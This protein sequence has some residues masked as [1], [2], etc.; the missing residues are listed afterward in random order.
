MNEPMTPVYFDTYKVLAAMEGQGATRRGYFIE[1]L[2]GAQFAMP[3]AVDRLRED[4][5]TSMKLL[6]ACDPANPWGASLEW[7]QSLGHRPSRKAGA[8]VVLNDGHP[9]IYLERG[10]HTLVSF[11]EDFNAISQALCLLGEWIDQHRISPVTI[12]RINS[13]PGFETPSW[14]PVFEQSGFVMTPQGFVRRRA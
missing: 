13:A 12:K 10:A 6:A 14:I 7:P 9:V 1:G 3:G 8:L 2:G 11:N 5:K 4:R